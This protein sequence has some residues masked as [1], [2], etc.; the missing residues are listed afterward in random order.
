MTKKKIIAIALVAVILIAGGIPAAIFI[1]R[2]IDANRLDMAI[3]SDIHVLSEEQMGTEMTPSLVEQ[4]AKGQKMLTL[5]FALL[6]EGVDKVIKE[7]QEVLIIPGDLT[8]DGG[9]LSHQAVARELKRAE[10]NGVECFVINGN[11]DINNRARSYKASEPTTVDNVNAEEFAEI[12]ADFGYNQALDRHSDSLSY[13]ARLNKEYRLIAID[14]CFYELEAEKGYCSSGRNESVVSDDL[15]EWIETS[16][17]KA[18]EDEK[19]VIA[20]MHFPLL[21]HL[22]SLVD[23]RAMTSDKREQ[24]SELFLDYDVQ[25]VF[26]GHLHSQNIESRE[27]QEGKTL[28]DI[29]TAALCNYPMPIR[30]FQGKPKKEI[31]TTKYLTSLKEEYIP[32]L[33]ST[34]IKAEILEDLAAYSEKIVDNGM[35]TKVM[36]KIDQSTVLAL[37]GVFDLDEEAIETVELVEDIRTNLV[38]DFFNTSIYEDGTNKSVQD[39][40]QSYGVTLPDSEYTTV[41][42]VA[43]EFLK[44][45]YRGNEGFKTTDTE[46]ILLKYSLYTAFYKIAEYDF[47][48]KLNEQNPDIPAIDLMPA[49]EN[50]FV[51][52]YLDVEDNGLLGVLGSVKALTSF[53][54]NWSKKPL[55]GN[56]IKNIDLSESRSIINFVDALLSLME[57]LNLNFSH[58][59]GEDNAIGAAIDSLPIAEIINYENGYIDLSRV[60]NLLYGELGENL[61]TD[62][63]PADDEL[64]VKKFSK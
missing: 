34:E 26:T 39:I 64:I 56:L 18:K 36:R 47:F 24:I 2:Y 14:C 30:F 27:N 1:P 16:L 51:Q 57:Q 21:D 12:Y 38:L 31:L 33:I 54:E 49:M 41:W 19:R 45:N 62:R 13:T 8:D 15:F 59:I 29:E 61:I 50:L 11:H 55:I 52:G 46:G 4:E 6:K 9:K 63:P 5:S 37:L 28:Y 23:S 53:Q 42:S 10:E 40:C 25:Y 44:A 43:M 35:K 32:S 60:Y 22:T 48:E 58:F 7:K 20:M 3:M 17:A